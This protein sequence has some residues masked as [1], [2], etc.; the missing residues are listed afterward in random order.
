MTER[1]TDNSGER[2]TQGPVVFELDE[3]Q[4]PQPQVSEAPPVPDP[5]PDMAQTGRGAVPASD[6]AGAAL[7]AARRPSRLARWFWGLVLALLGAVI[8]LAAWDFAM[9]LI[10]RLPLLGWAV[11]AGFALALALALIMVLRELAALSR[12]KRVDYLR[13]SAP[14]A[15]RD[16]AAAR[17]HVSRLEGFTLAARISAGSWRAWLSVRR[18][19]WTR[20]PC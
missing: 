10:P 4:H 11:S 16:I 20:M 3:E 8:S 12:L 9:G 7:G 18:M 17:A 5:V 2:P 19:C 15:T 6:V 1:M 13:Q 14:A